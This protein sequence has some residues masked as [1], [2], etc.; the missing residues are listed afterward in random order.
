MLS[1]DICNCLHI[2][3]SIA[4]LSPDNCAENYGGKDEL[5]VQ[6]MRVGEDAHAQEE[7]DD[8]VAEKGEDE[9]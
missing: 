5:P 1:P 6:L 3:N 9:Y 7:E 4:M 8:A 2:T